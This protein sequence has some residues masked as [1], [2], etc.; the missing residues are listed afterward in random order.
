[1]AWL[2]C[3]SEN[4][5]ICDNDPNTDRIEGIWAP[6][7]GPS[8]HNIGTGFGVLFGTADISFNFKLPE[9]HSLR[10]VLPTVPVCS[11]DGDGCHSERTAAQ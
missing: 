4:I 6:N 2:K 11:R 3:N 9:P 10:S 5:D 8:L 7:V 1:M